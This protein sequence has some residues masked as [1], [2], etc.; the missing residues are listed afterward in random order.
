MVV[1][2]LAG[3]MMR[4]MGERVGRARHL[5]AHVSHEEPREAVDYGGF[6]QEPQVEVF[7]QLCL[8]LGEGEAQGE[9]CVGEEEP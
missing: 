3:M 1:Y 9:G 5:D 6:A 4:C 7:V 2:G 8:H